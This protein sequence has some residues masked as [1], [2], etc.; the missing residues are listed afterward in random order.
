MLIV[1]KPIAPAKWR[2]EFLSH[3]SKMP[4]PELVFSTIHCH[5][6]DSQKSTVPRARFCIYRGMWGELSIHR[7]NP[8]ELNESVYQSELLTITTDVRMVKIHDIFDRGLEN[9]RVDMS[10]GGGKVEALFWIKETATQWRFL[11]E[12]FV[13]G[14]DIDDESSNGA[15]LVKKKLGERMRVVNAD[16]EEKWSWSR[17]LTAHFGNLSPSMRGTFKNPPP[18]VPISTTFDNS[19]LKLGQIVDDLHDEVARKNFRVIII[20]PEKVEKLDLNCPL[21]TRRRWLYTYTR[22][23]NNTEPDFWTEEECWP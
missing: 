21:E 19:R 9:E 7:Q 13:V 5:S 20:K 10:G 22:N 12:A 3:I 15:K 1:T 17:E 11:G 14:N 4:S 16:G 8:A 23:K 6:V 2:A 18:G